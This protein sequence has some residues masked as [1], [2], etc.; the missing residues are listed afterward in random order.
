MGT[1]V[2]IDIVDPQVLASD[3]EKVFN[4]LEQVEEK[5]SVF[6]VSSEISRINRGELNHENYSA[7]MKEIFSLAAKTKVETNGYFDI[8][9]DKGQFNPSGIVKG[10]AISKAADLLKVAG[11]K[12]FYVE[13]GGDI[14]VA[15]KNSSNNLWRV[16]IR[17]PFDLEKNVKIL[18]L[19]NCGIATSGIYLRGQ[20]I[21]N[22]HNPNEKFSDIV[23]LT[24]VAKNAYEADRF[25]TAAFAMGREGIVWLENFPELEAYMID[26]NGQATF[27]SGFEKYITK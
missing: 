14:E 27:T 11:F 5:F 22:P 12:N 15:G 26:K 16:G 21:Y 19:D 8:V 18:E 6:K 2:T 17:N 4:Y 13:I 10:W 3:I 7:E 9:T 24:V 20:H 25:A 1:V 23:S